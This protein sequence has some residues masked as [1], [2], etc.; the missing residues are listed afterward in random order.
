MSN[1][2]ALMMPGMPGRHRHARV[3]EGFSNQTRDSCVPPRHREQIGPPVLV[4]VG[5]HHVIPAAQ[6]GG[7]RVLDQIPRRRGL[8]VPGD[9]PTSAMTAAIAVINA[10]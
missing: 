3:H 2:S 9:R 10:A 7:N 4:H 5:R 1:A 8:A 6:V